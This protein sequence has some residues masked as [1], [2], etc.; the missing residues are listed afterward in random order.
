MSQFGFRSNVKDPTPFKTVI[1]PATKSRTVTINE[2][3]LPLVKAR[4]TDPGTA[5]GSSA[6][7]EVEARLVD[8]SGG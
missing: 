6:V 1:H 2:L 8:R 4:D 7:S 3:R 5:G